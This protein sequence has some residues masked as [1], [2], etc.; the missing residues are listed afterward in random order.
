MHANPLSMLAI[1]LGAI[2]AFLGSAAL[3][4][5]AF[6]ESPFWRMVT[7]RSLSGKV[8]FGL[9]HWSDAKFG[10]FNLIVGLGLLLTGVY[11]IPYLRADFE[12]EYPLPA[13]GRIVH[14]RPD[15]NAQ[16][17]EHRERLET[18][19]V[20]FSEDGQEVVRQ[21][22][23]LE[24][25]RKALNSTDTA[26]VVKFNEE[27]AAYQARNTARRQ[28]QEKIA[29]LQDELDALLDARS[30]QAAKDLAKN[31][32]IVIYTMPRCPEAEAAMQYFDR[33]GLPYE[34]INVQTRAGSDAFQ[35]LHGYVLP[36]ILV[37]EKRVDGF[38][39][40]ALD[41]ILQM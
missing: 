34:E 19:Q 32:K 21:Y 17:Q 36:L 20:A 3:Q 38:K 40:P 14:K 33:K 18:L 5:Q 30:R 37:G 10:L 6:Q 28:T 35:K 41:A 39:A 24:A 31:G 1:I 23:A 25:E 26:T 12:K 15:W 27:V 7:Y 11:T 13:L 8:I 29:V 16:I 9:T 4:A 22:R 2:M